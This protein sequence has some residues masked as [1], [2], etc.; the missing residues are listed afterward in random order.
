M[1]KSSKE[2][3]NELTENEFEKFCNISPV[4]KYLGIKII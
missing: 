3:L 4:E 2:K 1:E